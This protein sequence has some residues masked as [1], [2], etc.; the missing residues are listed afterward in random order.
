MKPLVLALGLLAAV[1]PASAN[2]RATVTSAPSASPGSA[3]ARS[4]PGGSAESI[5]VL[6]SI[7]FEPGKPAIAKASYPMLDKMAAML[8]QSKDLALVE[9]QVHTDERGDDKWNLKLSQQQAEQILKALVARGVDAR[10]LVAQGYGETQPLDRSHAAKA[11]A[12][13][14]RTA[15][16]VLKRTT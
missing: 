2:P 9:I 8:K 11:W 12:K 13:N 7:R 6:E 3:G 14:R 5:E 10:R 16:L 15:L 4:T 1:R